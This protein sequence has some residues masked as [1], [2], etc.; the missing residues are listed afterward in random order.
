MQVTRTA[1]DNT[2][3]EAVE[4]WD[5][6]YGEVVIRSMSPAVFPDGVVDADLRAEILRAI[7]AAE[8]E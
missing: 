4:W 6:P 7:E 1:I 5:T 3:H 2:G 8:G